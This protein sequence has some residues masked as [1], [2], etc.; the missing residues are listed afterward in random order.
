M[1][2][3]TPRPAVERSRLR[4]I[5]LVALSTS[6]L[7]AR[8]LR[9]V[10][11]ALGI[12]IGI[13]AMVAVLGI[14]ASSQ[15]K[16][17]QQ[18]DAL[19]TNL[20]TVEAGQDLFGAEA[21]LPKDSEG[22][23]GRV[24]GAQGAAGVGAL[25]KIRIYRSELIPE[26]QSGGLAVRAADTSLADVLDLSV[27]S[28]AWL[29]EAMGAY[30]SVVLGDRTARQLGIERAGSLVWLGGQQFAVVG[31]LAPVELAPELDTS[32]LV[33]KQVALDRLDYDGAPTR[34]YMR[35][36]EETLAET[37]AL[38]PQ[39]LSPEQPETITVSRPSDA[40]AAKAA[41]DETFTGLLLGLGSLGLLV[42][43]IGVANT[44]II[45]VIER[46]REIG[47]RRAIGARRSHIRRQ[48][49]GEAL[50]LSALGGLG[51]AGIGALVTAGF[52]RSGGLPFTLPLYVPAAAIAAT[53]VV[54]AIA[55]ISPAWRAARV[56][57]TVAL[58][59]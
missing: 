20:L 40:L 1:S 38:L 2:R 14:S 31:I 49:L 23:I 53:L 8:P 35:A 3:A 26:A 34:M 37:R 58:S 7:R 29:N 12:A 32:A 21:S 6:G 44:M 42:G 13:A 22:R 27:R 16:L 50:V 5:D 9:A 48:F 46:R 55:G 57:P 17:A 36:N 56:P 33:G 43:G 54:G 45:S 25:P 47:L 10:L 52:A 30:P 41:T 4:A 18:L 51:G 39:T 59:G 28:G 19:G 24:A 15:A 11:S